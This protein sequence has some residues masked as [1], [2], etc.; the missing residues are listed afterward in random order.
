MDLTFGCI[1]WFHSLAANHHFTLPYKHSNK[2]HIKR[3]R[4][5]QR[6]RREYTTKSDDDPAGAGFLE[7]IV[8]SAEFADLS[9]LGFFSMYGHSAGCRSP[10]LVL[11]FSDFKKSGNGGQAHGKQGT[12]I[13]LDCQKVQDTGE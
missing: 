4:C 6:N 13:Y 12:Y 2:S 11:H 10:P 8:L 5:H 7:G 1:R 9:K 3:N